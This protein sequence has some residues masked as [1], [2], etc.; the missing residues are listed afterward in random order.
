MSMSEPWLNR[1]GGGQLAWQATVQFEICGKHCVCL[2]GTCQKATNHYA[3]W[4]LNEG[5]QS[6]NQ[7]PSSLLHLRIGTELQTVCG[8]WSWLC[9]HES[10]LACE[11]V[12]QSKPQQAPT[13][14]GNGRNKTIARLVQAEPG[15]H[16][17]GAQAICLCLKCASATI[18]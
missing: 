10:V 12:G 14:M 6:K 2:T 7:A 15:A 13:N 9:L 3:L 8:H 16:R 11:G 5:S 17:L 18:G 4:F 1:S